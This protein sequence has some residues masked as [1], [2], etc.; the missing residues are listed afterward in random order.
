MVQ[1]VLPLRQEELGVPPDHLIELAL[2]LTDGA[3]VN[4]KAAARL[5][6]DRTAMSTARAILGWVETSRS[7]YS[8]SRPI[9]PNPFSSTKATC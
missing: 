9:P 6:E 1:T 5:A 4:W 2:K 3:S 7:S 8:G